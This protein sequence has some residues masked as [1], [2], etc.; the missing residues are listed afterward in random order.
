MFTFICW[1]YLHIKDSGYFLRRLKGTW[2]YEAWKEE[3]M[4]K[5]DISKEHT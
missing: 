3:E 4:K 5:S 1:F 2:K